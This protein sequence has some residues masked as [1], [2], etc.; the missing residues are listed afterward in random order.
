[1]NEPIVDVQALWAEILSQ[2]EL[3]MSA[4]VFHTWLSRSAPLNLTNDLLTVA[5][6]TP[7]AKEAISHRLQHVIDKTVE[8]V[9]G[10]P[11]R[12]VFTVADRTGRKTSLAANPAETQRSAVAVGKSARE[13]EPEC[14]RELE[15]VS[16]VDLVEF[17]P[18][19]RGWVKSPNYAIRF[20]QPYLT[21]IPFAVWLVLRSFAY[22]D[23]RLAWPSVQT[24]ADICAGGNRCLISGRAAHKGHK[25]RTVGAL[26][27]LESERIIW[28]KRHGTGRS[29]SYAYRV[30][31]FLPLL[32]PT[33][34]QRLSRTRQEAHAGF[35]HRAYIDLEEWKKLTLPTLTVPFA[36]AD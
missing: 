22:N 9:C 1:M 8:R 20:W 33:Q 23:Y 34:V 2:L 19:E 13:P 21:N 12:T 27:T 6:A 14:A 3:Q 30:L 15:P 32:T 35:L 7:Q 26:E 31:D 10:R 18:T 16:A 29:T 11:L 25:R 17:D 5:V 28:I 24:L 4:A 36:P